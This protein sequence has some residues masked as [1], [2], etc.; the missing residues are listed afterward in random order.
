MAVP[1]S[2]RAAKASAD[3]AR[4]GVAPTRLTSASDRER[5]ASTSATYT[6]NFFNVDTSFSRI[7]FERDHPTRRRLPTAH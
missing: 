4:E 5:V 3:A 1:N 6:F 2:P 7:R